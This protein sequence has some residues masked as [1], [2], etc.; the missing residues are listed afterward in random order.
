MQPEACDL[1]PATCGLEPAMRL[2][3]VENA[4]DIAD[5]LV[6]AFNA[7]GYAADIALHGEQ[8]AE[9]AEV[10]DY[11]LVVLD[12]CRELRRDSNVPIVMLTR[13]GELDDRVK[14]LE[15]GATTTSLSRSA[16]RS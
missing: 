15:A 14:G 3:I 13:R 10:N 6:R 12:V 11:D 2:L 9:L 7:Q 4:S 5:L 16:S 8:G 1:R